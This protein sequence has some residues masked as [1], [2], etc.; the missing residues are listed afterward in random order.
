MPELSQESTNQSQE[1]Q[2]S[3]SQ[4]VTA[5]IFDLTLAEENVVDE[6]A[7]NDHTWEKIESTTIINWLKRQD[8]E[9]YDLPEA[10]FAKLDKNGIFT[11]TVKCNRENCPTF[12]SRETKNKK[13]INVK[14]SHFLQHLKAAH[15]IEKEKDLPAAFSRFRARKTPTISE[16]N[17]Q[18]ILEI[19][20]SI[21]S[22]CKLPMSFFQREAIK[23]RDKAMMRSVGINEEVIDQYMSSSPH[24]MKEQ[25][26]KNN[27]EMKKIFVE[28]GPFLVEDG[29]MHLEI[30]HKSIKKGTQDEEK[31]GFGI[32]AILNYEEIHER[33]M[34]SFKAT[35]YTDTATNVILLEQCLKEYG[36]IDA[37]KEK[38]I[39]ISGDS[40]M[41]G[42]MEA[43]ACL[44]T[45]CLSHTLGCAVDGIRAKSPIFGVEKS[46]FEGPDNFVKEARKS[47]KIPHSAPKDSPK[48]ISKYLQNQS[49]TEV[50]QL[51]NFF[52]SFPEQYQDYDPEDEKYLAALEAAKNQ[53]KSFP[54]IKESYFSIRFGSMFSKYKHILENSRS[55][56]GLKLN[57][58]PKYSYLLANIDLPDMSF[59]KSV[60]FFL[61]KAHTLL[62]ASEQRDS[63]VL[64]VIISMENLVIDACRVRSTLHFE[65]EYVLDQAE[66]IGKAVVAKII[67]MCFGSVWLPSHN[68]KISGIVNSPSGEPQRFVEVHMV[69]ALLHWPYRQLKLHRMIRALK[70]MDDD[71]FF[72]TNRILIETKLKEWPEIAKKKLRFLSE[73]IEK[74]SSI[75]Q[76]M[77]GDKSQK[78]QSADIYDD[79]DKTVPVKGK[80]PLSKLDSE[81]QI[82]FNLS[83]DQYAEWR[84]AKVAPEHNPES[85]FFRTFWEDHKIQMPTLSKIAG[86]I[87]R[88]PSSSN[89]AE[90]EFSCLSYQMGTIFHNQKA[91]HIE[92]K[93]QTAEHGRFKEALKKIAA[94]KGLKTQAFGTSEASKKIKITPLTQPFVI[95]CGKKNVIKIV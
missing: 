60:F 71:C 87:G 89:E 22:E 83:T 41:V 24:M 39:I 21:L 35:D 34:M 54:K 3:A 69:A 8:K 49:I 32:V 70:E 64:E 73:K 27:E 10:F 75:T 91:A 6:A 68:D 19:E 26:K 40:K 76:M 25:M 42:T 84:N 53:F 36:L 88:L 44:W 15:K 31:H 9:V 23:K 18:E 85:F 63:S 37:W 61:N 1:I 58:D 28:I 7:L 4:Q 17:K 46:K 74:N 79:D 14:T 55:L 52:L 92:K 90:R 57:L 38:R 95:N 65:Q 2:Q 43:H 67:S 62:L 11:G 30:D 47:R 94:R 93:Q 82:Y 16:K 86:K 59:M 20:C 29:T 33:Y 80:I 56:N 66:K 51:D 13:N 81:L 77:T 78:G 72:K 45:I 48:S 12:V 5:E 50:A